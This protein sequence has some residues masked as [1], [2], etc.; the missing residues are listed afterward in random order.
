MTAAKR[1]CKVLHLTARADIGG[2][3]EHVYQLVGHL[4]D[5]I[6]SYIACPGEPPYHARYTDLVGAERMMELPHRAFNMAALRSLAQKIRS[7]K[8]NLLHSHGKGAGLYSRLLGPMTGRPVVHTFHG[9]HEG[10]YGTAARV[11]YRSFERVSGLATRAAICVSA[12]EHD[13]IAAA[14]LMPARKLKVIPNGVVISAPRTAEP[15]CPPLRVIAVNR[16]DRQKNPDLLIEIARQVSELALPVRIT[17]FGAGERLDECRATVRRENLKEVISF[18][19]PS[20]RVREEMR[21]AHVFVSSSRWEGMPLAVLEAMAEGLPVV[22]TD[23]VGNRDVV[24]TEGTAP[25]GQLFPLEDPAGGRSGATAP[26]G[27]RLAEPGRRGR[28]HPCADALFRATH[29]R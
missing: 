21:G 1:P 28:P 20:A 16:F 8:I 7:E 27:P 22:L 23:V 13:Q 19:G 3:P 29:G 17:V 24:E 14:R 2:G 25:S 5:A 15:D 4:P 26:D 6:T 9:L 10:S 12:G 11:A 18:E